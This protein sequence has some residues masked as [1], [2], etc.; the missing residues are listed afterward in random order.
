MSRISQTAKNSRG[1]GLSMD[2]SFQLQYALELNFYLPALRR[3]Q[4]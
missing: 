4:K 2:V 3:K 1:S